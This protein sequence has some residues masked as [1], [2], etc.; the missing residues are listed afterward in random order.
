MILSLVGV[1]VSQLEIATVLRLLLVCGLVSYLGSLCILP[2]NLR[3]GEQ[4]D[5]AVYHRTGQ[6][7]PKIITEE[8]EARMADELILR[9][10]RLREDI[11]HSMEL[12]AIEDSATAEELGEGISQ[13]SILAKDFRSVHVDLQDA[14]QGAYNEKYSDYKTKLDRL[15]NFVKKSREK[16]RTLVRLKETALPDIDTILAEEERILYRIRQ[17]DFSMSQIDLAVKVPELETFLHQMERLLEQ[18][19]NLCF[20]YKRVARPLETDKQLIQFEKMCRYVAEEIKITKILKHKL[21]ETTK[22][23]EFDSSRKVMRDNCVLTAESLSSEICSRLEGLQMT[24]LQD[25]DSLSDYQILQVSQ[26]SNHNAEFNEILSKI[27]ELTGLVP[28][29][30]RKV[31]S[32]LNQIIVRKN[33]VDRSKKFFEEKLQKIVLDKDITP[34]KLRNACSIKIELPKF[35]GYECSMDFFTF[36][37]Q[38]QKL[39]EP[40]NQKPYLADVLKRN[41]LSGSAFK[42]VERETDYAKIWEMLQGSYGNTRLMLQNKLS[43][44]DRMGGLW[45]VKADEKIVLALASLTNTM[46]DLASLAERHGLEGSLYEGGALVGCLGRCLGLSLEAL[47]GYFGSLFRFRFGGT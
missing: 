3:E 6:K 31:R 27:T 17:L 24:Y 12:Y 43:E 33:S 19:T 37:T 34:D 39:V 20:D 18:Y 16:K 13:I 40:R 44:L 14:L 32:M 46:S 15:T 38:F 47:W 2:M 1:K 25:L 29:G 21:V 5:Y 26:K 42:L 35:S 7:I 36:K 8:P 9:E 23:I 4:F 11:L 28:T 41:Y 10:K 45:H 30:G 22:T